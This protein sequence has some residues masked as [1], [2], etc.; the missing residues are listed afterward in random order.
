MGIR[1]ATGRQTARLVWSSSHLLVL[2]PPNA[3]VAAAAAEDSSCSASPLHLCSVKQQ[4]KQQRQQQRHD[5][6]DPKPAARSSTQ[7]PWSLTCRMWGTWSHADI[8]FLR[9]SEEQ[10]GYSC[11]SRFYLTGF[12]GELL[13]CQGKSEQVSSQ[14]T[15]ATLAWLHCSGSLLFCCS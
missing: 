2:S 14:I 11:F 4:Q 1:V 9:E 15:L 5:R 12:F 7:S 6:L 3:A 8:C 10:S 13:C